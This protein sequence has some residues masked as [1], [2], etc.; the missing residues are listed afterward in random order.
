MVGTFADPQARGSMATFRTRAAAEE[1]VAGDPFVKN[2]VV[3]S[4]DIRE[5]P[6]ILT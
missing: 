3:A 4:H 5:R 1:L 2:G 6:E